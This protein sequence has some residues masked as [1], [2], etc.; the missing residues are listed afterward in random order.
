VDEQARD[1]IEHARWGAHAHHAAGDRELDPDHLVPPETTV[2]SHTPDR[3]EAV[4]AGQ[5][6]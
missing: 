4:L 1:A 5:R 6:A 2:A 3:G